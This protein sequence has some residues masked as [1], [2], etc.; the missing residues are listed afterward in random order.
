MENR[1][2]TIHDVPRIVT[3]TPVTAILRRLRYHARSTIVSPAQMRDVESVI[4]TATELCRPCGR[5]TRVNVVVEQ[6]T[7]LCEGLAPIKSKSLEKL[8][9]KS[10]QAAVL[11]V[12]VGKEI[13]ERIEML[14]KEK[15]F[16]E[17][18][19]YDAVASE[20]TEAAMEYLH[21]YVRQERSRFG[22]GVTRRYS[23]GYG[24]LPL[25][26]QQIL[27]DAL[28]MGELGVN[29][30]PRHMLIPEKSTLAIIG[31]ENSL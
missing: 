30:S 16:V 9:T 19:I 2:L 15:Q 20:K 11:G 3:P 6:E 5:Y 26:C 25:A 10:S 24:D 29:L 23:P 1:T 4:R 28:R 21:N 31:I 22:Q 14:V 17:G 27:Y 7:V 8:L 13:V 18:V 12:T